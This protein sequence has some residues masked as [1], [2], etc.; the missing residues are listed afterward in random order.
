MLSLD[1]VVHFL[2]EFPGADDLFAAAGFALIVDC[3]WFVDLRMVVA[4]WADELFYPNLLF[5]TAFPAGATTLCVVLAVVVAV[6]AW[7]GILCFYAPDLDV[8]DVAAADFDALFVVVFGAGFLLSSA[9]AIF[10]LLMV[11]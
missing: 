9:S 4:C 8:V 6:G 1:K 3:A 7:P 10:G 11:N 2:T 5:A